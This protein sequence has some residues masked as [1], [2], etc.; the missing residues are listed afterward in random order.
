MDCNLFDQSV[1]ESLA[2]LDLPVLSFD[3]LKRRFDPVNRVLPKS[4]LRENIANNSSASS[5]FVIQH[6]LCEIAYPPFGQIIRQ[7]GELFEQ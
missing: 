6:N 4:G 3:E 2:V 7:N 1:H 5:P